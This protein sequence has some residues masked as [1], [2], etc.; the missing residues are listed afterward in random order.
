M[1][2]LGS[3]LSDADISFFFCSIWKG[4]LQNDGA[5]EEQFSAV[6]PHSPFSAV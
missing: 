4:L 3:S 2:G 6:L 1:G 5:F